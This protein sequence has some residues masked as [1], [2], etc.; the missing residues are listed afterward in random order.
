MEKLNSSQPEPG[1]GGVHQ[2][3]GIV[4]VSRPTLALGKK[5]EGKAAK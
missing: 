3:T 4:S 1:V 2:L 5:D